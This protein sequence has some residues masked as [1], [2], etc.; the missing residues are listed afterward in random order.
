MKAAVERELKLE[1]DG[2]VELDR[3]GGDPIESQHFSSIYHDASDLRLL[4]AGITL[5][6]RTENGASVWQLKLPREDARLELEEPGGPTSIPASIAAVL[7]GIVRGQQVVPI[8]TLATHRSGRRV[9]GIEV[10][11]DEVEVLEDR[12]VV[13]RFTEVEAELVGGPVEA[14]DRMGRKLRELGAHAG[15]SK[16]KVLRVVEVPERT[17]AGAKATALEALRVMVGAQYDELLRCDPIVRVSDDDEAVH[18]MRVAVRR[19]RSVLRTAR[20]MLHRGPRSTGGRADR[21]A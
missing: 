12:H 13:Q 19:L 6:R 5:R 14:L 18:K 3:L 20:P 1:G 15:A 10:T 11:V 4:R 2:E 17:E 7:S 8:A 21:R 16:P 9:D